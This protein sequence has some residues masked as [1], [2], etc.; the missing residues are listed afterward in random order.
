[1]KTLNILTISVFL[2]GCGGGGFTAGADQMSAA[3]ST[4]G[5][6]GENNIAGNSS[7]VG[8]S[9]N[10]GGN[11]GTENIAGNSS[12]AGMD[13][14]G[15]NSSGGIGGDISCIPKITCETYAISH[16]STKQDVPHRLACGQ[17][18]DDCGNIIECGGCPD[19]Y[20]GCGLSTDTLTPSADGPVYNKDAVPGTLNICGG[21]CFKSSNFIQATM[22]FEYWCYNSP[23]NPITNPPDPSCKFYS[24]LP[25]NEYPVPNHVA[26]DCGNN[27]N[28][29][30][31]GM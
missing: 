7:N 21:G 22:N 11:A 16:S 30:N 6:A 23:I 5:E 29:F 24:L 19:Y 31:T 18:I 14:G 27:G 9:E 26:F 8:G 2:T 10:N 20:G 3:G 28:L 12:I 1:M 15:S 25:S 4:I 17:L 13:N